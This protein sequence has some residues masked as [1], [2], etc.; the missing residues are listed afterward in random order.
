M[1]K[2]IHK[3]VGLSVAL[4]IIHL[5]ITGILLMYPGAFK[6][7]NTF[8][9][10]NYV[11]SLYNMYQTTDV[12]HNKDYSNIGIVSKKVII[13]DYVIDTGLEKVLNIAKYKKQIFINSYN[14]L[15]LINNKEYEPTIIKKIPFPFILKTMALNREKE[16]NFI[17]DKS[18]IYYLN[19]DFNFVPMLNP[20]I[21]LERL[22]LINADRD[23]A[24]LYLNYVQG[25]GIQLLR[26][27]TDIH[28]GRF[29]GRI[30]MTIFTVSSLAVIFLALSGT[31]M[32]FNISFKRQLYKKK[33][34]NISKK[35]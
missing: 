21:P 7:Q 23:T 33:K 34:K 12:F 28:N 26:F 25:P 9:S 20:K 17:D 6:L 11:L 24:E 19:N 3:I 27:I 18:V 10:N 5:A 35:T 22:F 1:L 2:K 32:S 16:I 30:V 29:F 4:I 8:I 31:F 14:N 15:L 13:D